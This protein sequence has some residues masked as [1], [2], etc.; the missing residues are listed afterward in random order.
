MIRR[1]FC[2]CIAQSNSWNVNLMNVG[3]L[4]FG[5]EDLEDQGFCCRRK[6]WTMKHSAAQTCHLF[7]LVLNDERQSLDQSN[8]RGDPCNEYL[9]SQFFLKGGFIVGSFVSFSC[10]D[11]FVFIKSS[12]GL[13]VPEE[14]SRCSSSCS[15]YTLFSTSHLRSQGFGGR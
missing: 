14:L 6:P 5:L 12:T 10:K 11:Q 3:R 7:N 15:V 8:H 4:P 13:A 9:Q 1:S 2:R